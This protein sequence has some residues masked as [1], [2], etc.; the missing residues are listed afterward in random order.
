MS[1]SLGALAFWDG[2]RAVEML[3][4]LLEG[5]KVTVQ[6][7]LLAFA[8]S[9][10]IGLVVA[11]PRFVRVPIL[12]PIMAAWVWFVRGTPLL[13]QAYFV[14]F[15]LPQFGIRMS[16]LTTGIV[17]LGINYSAYTAEIYRAGI[18]AVPRGQWEATRALD[19]PSPAVWLRIILPQ[20]IPPVIPM[21]GNYLIQM[22]KDCAILSAIG[23]SEMLLKTQ[24]FQGN[25]VEAYTIVG[26]LYLAISYPAALLVKYLERRYVVSV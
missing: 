7:T 1:D 6:V 5:L 16:V 2:Q 20:A 14:F 12:S 24:D 22:F 13:V 23:V 8:L 15:V 10:I 9:L 11:I 17:V 3:P 26:A 19:L 25:P 18:E 21:L 4:T